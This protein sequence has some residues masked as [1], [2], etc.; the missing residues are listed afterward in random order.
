MAVADR[1]QDLV[2]RLSEDSATLV[3]SEIE[4]AKAE[5]REKVGALAKAAA[6]GGVAAVLSLF[7]LFAL[8]QAVIDALDLAMPAW[9]AALIV[10]L[11]LLGVA[12][13][14]GLLAL[15]SIKRGTPPVP[16]QAVAEA[17][18]VAETLRE[19]RA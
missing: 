7:G 14:A 9:L 6:F 18:A 4:L 16:E 5:V 15:R 2:T 13:V 8:V 19:A 17:R 10:A 1:L 11:A 12:G 3:R